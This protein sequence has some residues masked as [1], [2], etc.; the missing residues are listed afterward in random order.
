MHHINVSFQD[1]T[2]LCS[3][4]LTTH[5]TYTEQRSRWHEWLE[6][7]LRTLDACLTPVSN[8]QSVRAKLERLAELQALCAEGDERLADVKQTNS[9]VQKS[10]S[11][12]GRQQLRT[13]ADNL[14]SEWQRFKARL[15]DSTSGLRAALDEW[16]SY[17]A[18]HDELSAWLRRCDAE[19]KANDVMKATA[20]DKRQQTTKLQV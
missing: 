15:E 8:K 17:D 13:E 4:Y 9:K 10:T 7:R 18:L 5:Q 19:V 11:T 12:S 6:T 3:E 20:N 2:Q 14:A 16:D 1:A